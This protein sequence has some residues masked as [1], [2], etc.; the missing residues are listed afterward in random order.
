MRDVVRVERRG[1]ADR[2]DQEEQD[3]RRKGDP[4]TD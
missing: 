1:E 3:Q 4:V 2:D